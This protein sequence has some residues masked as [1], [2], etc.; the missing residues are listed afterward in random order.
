V[1]SLR[2]DY[3]QAGGN[4]EVMHHSELLASLIKEG[5]LPR[6]RAESLQDGSVTYHDPC[7]LARVGGVT[8]PPRA[9]LAGVG[10]AD[11]GAHFEELP[12]NRRQTACCG[13]GGGRMWFDDPP[14]ERVGQGRVLEI[15]QS[16]AQNVAVGCPFCLIMLGD[17]LATQRPETHVRDIAEILADAVLGPEAPA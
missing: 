8:E 14:A 7:Y 16:G 15:I 1:N 5:R 13:A 9:V 10:K 3:P 17:G 12:R 4:Y 2:N 6:V 11:A